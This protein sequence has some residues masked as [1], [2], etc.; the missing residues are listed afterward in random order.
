[1]HI[2]DLLQYWKPAAAGLA[3][4]GINVEDQVLQL[5]HQRD[6]LAHEDPLWQSYAQAVANPT[7][8]VKTLSN[9]EMGTRRSGKG[10]RICGKL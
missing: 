8:D 10:G 2:E 3:A 6:D 7:S 5:R 4:T 1:M 9:D